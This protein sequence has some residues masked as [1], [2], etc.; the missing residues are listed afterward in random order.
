MLP[1]PAAAERGPASASRPAGPARQ[2]AEGSRLREARTSAEVITAAIAADRSALLGAVEAVP[3]SAEAAAKSRRTASAPSPVPRARP[4]DRLALAVAKRSFPT[5][6]MALERN[7]ADDDANA[8]PLAST[9]QAVASGYGRLLFLVNVLIDDGLYPDF[10]RPGERGFPV[11]IWRLLALLGSALTGPALRNDALWGLLDRLADELP[12]GDDCAFD[13]VWPIPIAPSC[14]HYRPPSEAHPWR[15]RRA[16]R[17]GFARWLARYQLSLR[18]RLAR[19]LAVTPAL[20]GSAFVQREGQSLL[21]V[22]AAEIVVVQALDE[23][24]V[25]W[26]LAGLDRDPGYL[27]S[28]G[29]KLRFVFE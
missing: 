25:E 17:H 13:R 28:A 23:H 3:A 10:T 1:I 19:A 12:I 20:V 6:A 8:W 18:A 26:R 27:P 9:P 14:R 11:P 16:P 29:R 22:S 24:P 4:A 15:L 21:W 7:T 5:T 2:P